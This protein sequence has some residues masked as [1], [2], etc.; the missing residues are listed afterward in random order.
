[1]VLE[2]LEDRCQVLQ[3]LVDD[4]LEQRRSVLEFIGRLQGD[5]RLAL[6]G[7]LFHYWVLTCTHRKSRMKQLA[8]AVLNIPSDVVTPFLTWRIFVARCRLDKA[9]QRCEVTDTQASRVA[10]RITEVEIENAEQQRKLQKSLDASALLKSS[11]FLEQEENDRLQRV[12]D[13][14]KPELL[15]EVLAHSLEFLFTLI[16]SSAS[17]LRLS[18]RQRIANRDVSLLYTTKSI[19][20]GECSVDDHLV[21]WINHC[22]ALARTAAAKQQNLLS[23]TTSTAV[24]RGHLETIMKARDVKNFTEDLA[25]SVALCAL[26]AVLRAQKD[27]RD[28]SAAD[29]SC[30]Q[31]RDTEIRAERLCVEFRFLAPT[32]QARCLLHPIDIAGGRTERLSVF[33][34]SLFLHEPLLPVLEEGTPKEE[35]LANAQLIDDLLKKLERHAATAA[36][37]PPDDPTPLLHGGEDFQALATASTEQL[38]L[39]W[40]NVQLASVFHRPVENFGSDLQDGE[41][42]GLLLSV[43]APE[44]MEFSEDPEERLDCIISAAVR[45]TDFELLTAQVILEGQSDML[46]AFLA[47]LFLSRP[48]LAAKP[49]S[50]LAMHLGLLEQ[51]CID[52]FQTFSNPNDQQ[53]II[54]MCMQLDS[55]WA[56]FTLAAQTVD[57]AAKAMQGVNSRMRTFL[58]DTLAHRAQGRP[59]VMLDAKEARELLI[60]TSLNA[61]HVQSL[62]VTEAVDSFVISRLED[63]MRKHFHLLREVFRFYSVPTATGSGSGMTLEG[64]MKLYQDCKLRSKVLAPRHIEV[65][66]VDHLDASAAQDRALSPG[67]FV[68]VLVGCANLKFK[69]KIETPHEQL[70]FLI[71]NHLKPHACQETASLFQHMAYNVKVRNILESHVRE[72][73]IIFQLYATMDTSSAEAM[74]R[75]HTMNIEEFRM[76][77]QHCEMMDG[78]FTESAM[79]EI[80]DGIQ[81]SATAEAEEDEGGVG[82]EGGEDDAQG[83]DDDEELSLSEFLDGL[84]AIAAYKF[85]DP[86]TAFDKR[87]NQFILKLFSAVQRHWS[88]KR[89]SPHVDNMLNA[90]QKKLRQ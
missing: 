19:A 28:F 42:I 15:L 40:A 66:F 10:N 20:V 73:K 8:G 76:L 23:L 77:L 62:F 3:R 14:T 34:T 17:L 48:N 24:A 65:L 90:L 47:Q 84:V 22:L 88:R 45:C 43:V 59:R 16:T 56:E 72:L 27:G 49:N 54:K 41:A 39:R 38:L 75:A 87:V 25:D 71:E 78:T 89:I 85:P 7:W 18:L 33:L 29:L 80:F 53:Q 61:A 37:Q 9:K 2:R 5:E 13:E 6:Q 81:Q 12:W 31:E 70:A 32:A 1:V 68:E 67:S 74:Q 50:L 60:Y 83:I 36:W 69:E 51:I 35:M 58:G 63:V 52:A 11:C 21:R 30:L 64:V 4:Q 79:R 26:L 57:E 55:Q 46:A 82:S 44:V 86:F